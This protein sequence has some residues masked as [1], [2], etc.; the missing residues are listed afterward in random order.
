[1]KPKPIGIIHSPFQRAATAA[2]RVGVRFRK[3]VCG[4]GTPRSEKEK[5]TDKDFKGR[6]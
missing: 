4:N 1:M 6:I 2:A 3:E 5:E